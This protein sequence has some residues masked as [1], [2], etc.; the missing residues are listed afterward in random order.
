MWVAGSLPPRQSKVVQGATP[1]GSQKL[2][3]PGPGLQGDWALQCPQCGPGDIGSRSWL[4]EHSRWW[5]P[6]EGA[7]LLKRAS[8]KGATHLALA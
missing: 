4:G 2:P 8:P 3:L 7:P 6:Q 1:L 5:H